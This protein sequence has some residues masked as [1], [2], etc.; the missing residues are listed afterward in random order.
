MQWLILLPLFSTT[1]IYADSSAEIE[2]RLQ[3]F[4]RVEIYVEVDSVPKTSLLLHT[5][6]RITSLR[7]LDT[8]G[9]GHDLV[10]V[11]LP[12]ADAV[13]LSR[14]L[15]AHPGRIYACFFGRSA[16]AS[17]PR[18]PH[19]RGSLPPDEEMAWF[20]VWHEGDAS[21]RLQCRGLGHRNRALTEARMGEML[22]KSHS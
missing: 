2:Q 16:V 19:Y 14:I 18:H 17:H 6:T 4:P 20:A 22:L 1:A 7:P 15:Q 10:S 12:P 3:T 9:A 11:R 5:I 21:L 8:D 13:V